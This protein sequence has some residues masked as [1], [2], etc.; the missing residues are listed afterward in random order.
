MRHRRLRFGLLAAA[1]SSTLV[2]GACGGGGGGG[3]GDTSAAPAQ[4]RVTVTA[5]TSTTPFNLQKGTYRLTWD[6]SECATI[7]LRFEGSTG[8]AKEKSSTLP[9]SSWL[10]TSVPDGAYTITQGEPACTQWQVV[11]ERIGGGAG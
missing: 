3:G 1:I 10:V 9:K 4:D 11:V 7:T 5:E 8:F 2:L 6:A